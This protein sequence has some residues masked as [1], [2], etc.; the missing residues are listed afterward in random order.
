MRICELLYVTKIPCDGWAKCEC[1]A[2][3][4]V[5][6]VVILWTGL[7]AVSPN[8]GHRPWE[9]TAPHTWGQQAATSQLWDPSKPCT[10]L[11]QLL[12][13][14]EGGQLAQAQCSPR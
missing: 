13:E 11:H 7:T 3:M 2:R 9:S 6:V 4:Y 10:Q 1:C 8:P 5:C 14:E 12:G